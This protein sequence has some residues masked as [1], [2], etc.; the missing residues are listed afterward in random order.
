[1]YYNA[2]TWD[3][4]TDFLDHFLMFDQRIPVN[5]WSL[6]RI[7]ESL[8]VKFFVIIKSRNDRKLL[9]YFLPSTLTKCFD[10]GKISLVHNVPPSISKLKNPRIFFSISFAAISLRQILYH[11]AIYN[12]NISGLVLPS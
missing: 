4:C 1:M 12:Y 8:G 11:G 2:I 9:Q 3:L 10:G 5:F 6:E 7:V